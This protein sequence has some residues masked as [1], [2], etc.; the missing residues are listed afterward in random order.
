[1]GAGHL[2]PL[3]ELT[4]GQVTL[5]YPVGTVEAEVEPPAGA[6]GKL[7]L[8]RG[9]HRGG[10]TLLAP[11]VLHGDGVVGLQPGRQLD[12]PETRQR[13]VGAPVVLVLGRATR[14]HRFAVQLGDE[15]TRPYAG[16]IRRTTRR[17][18]VHV[19]AD[20]V[21]LTSLKV[22]LDPEP[23]PPIE[24]DLHHPVRPVLQVDDL[25]LLSGSPGR[26]G[27]EAA[28]REERADDRLTSH[29]LTLRARAPRDWRG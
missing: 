25:R 9:H 18:R 5:A 13:L 23:C 15:V 1:V 4:C 27:G 11:A 2:E 14:Q 28:R 21:S 8:G 29:E 22:H 7:R 16:L 3:Q 17:D 19:R 26:G 24:H 20:R 10:S 12:E 6:E